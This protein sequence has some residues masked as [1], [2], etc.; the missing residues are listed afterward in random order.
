MPWRSSSIKFDELRGR[1]VEQGRAGDPAVLKG[2]LDAAAPYLSLS[3]LAC[4]REKLSWEESYELSTAAREGVDLQLVL[5]VATGHVVCL[6][7][8]APPSTGI[9]AGPA[10]ADDG[11]GPWAGDSADGGSPGTATNPAPVSAAEAMV[12]V[13]DRVEWA[14]LVDAEGVPEDGEPT[15][16]GSHGA[17]SAPDSSI[18]PEATIPADGHLDAPVVISGVPGGEPDVPGGRREDQVAGREITEEPPEQRLR[19][20]PDVPPP[21]LDDRPLSDDIASGSW[22]LTTRDALAAV[23]SSSSERHALAIN[24]V[25]WGLVS[26]GRLGL[27]YHLGRDLEEIRQPLQVPLALVEALVL[28][29]LVRSASS[30]GI[31]RLR[32]CLRELRPRMNASPPERPDRRLLGLALELCSLAACLRPALLAS[33]SG[34]PDLLKQLALDR[35]PDPFRK[36]RDVALGPSQRNLLL[37]ASLL[38]GDRAGERWAQSLQSLQR[39]CA[40]WL[41]SNRSGKVIYAA[42]TDVWRR[43]L[44]DD[45]PIGTM[46]GRVIRNQADPASLEATRKDMQDWSNHGHVDGKLHRTDNDLRQ[47]GAKRK[48]I[49]ARAVTAIRDRC[50]EAVALAG[51]WLNLLENRPDEQN[52]WITERANECRNELET[53]IGFGEGAVKAALES[54]GVTI[55][56][57]LSAGY[58]AVQRALDDLKELMNSKDDGPDRGAS[59]K[60]RLHG[61]LLKI[62]GLERS[63]GWEPLEPGSELLLTGTL[64]LVE[65]GDRRWDEV[66]A[67]CWDRDDFLTAQQIFELLEDTGT[68]A[69]GGIGPGSDPVAMRSEHDRRLGE[70]RANLCE[71][72]KELGEEIEK[73]RLKGLIDEEERLDLTDRLE[74]I[75]GE[76]TW[77]IARDR[78][79]LE[80]IDDRLRISKRERIEDFKKELLAHGLADRFPNG[81]GRIL[82]VLE[83]EDLVTAHEYRTIIERGGELPTPM[84]SVP[85]FDF[86]EPPE[87]GGEDRGFYYRLAPL[88]FGDGHPPLLRGIADRISERSPLGSI[89]VDVTPAQAKQAAQI[90]REWNQLKGVVKSRSDNMRESIQSIF[91]FI[92]FKIK[93]LKAGVEVL[94]GFRFQLETEPIVSRNDCILPD[95]GS[96]CD[97]K[98]ELLCLE[99][100]PL[101]D[102][103]L[104]IAG[105]EVQSHPVIVLF[106]APMKSRRRRELA[107]ALRLRGGRRLLVLDDVL[108]TYLCLQKDRLP[109]FFNAASQFS[110]AEPYLTTSSIPPEMFFGRDDEIASVFNQKGTSL[111][112]GGR[113]LGKTALLNEVRRR[114]HA[115]DRGVLVE[116]ID[117]RYGEHLGLSNPLD[118]I[119]RVIASRLQPHGVLSPSSRQTDTIGKE[120]RLWVENTGRRIVLLLDEADHFLASD[121]AEGWPRV[122]KLKT[123]MHDTH[124]QFKVVFS[125][126][127]NVQR[128]SHDV[129]TPLAHL[130]VPICIGPFLRDAE[131]RD[132]MDMVRLP[133]R[134]MGYYF[135]PPDLI[136]RILAQSNYY[137]SLIQLVCRQLLKRLPSSKSSPIDPERPPPSLSDSV[138]KDPLRTPPYPIKNSD[139]EEAYT[140]PELRKQIYDRFRW[141]LELDNSYR[142]IALCLALETL[143]NSERAVEG[144]TLREIREWALS[145]WPQ[146]FA[147]S[148]TNDAFR[149]LLDEMCELGVLRLR[150]GGR[151]SMRSPNVIHLLGTQE[152]IW[153]SLADAAKESR[154]IEYEAKSFRRVYDQHN[155]WRRSPLTA[156]QESQLQARSVHGLFVL[157]GTEAA[158]LDEVR[159]F[160]QILARSE[161]PSLSI[162]A[163]DD[164]VDGA[165]FQ[166]RLEDVIKQRER[167]CTMIL[168]DRRCRWSAEWV[169]RAGALL[170]RRHAEKHRFVKVLFLGG[171]HEAWLWSEL[172]EARRNRLA[173]FGLVEMALP[174]WNDLAVR[175]WKKEAEFGENTDEDSRRFSDATGNWCLFLHEVGGRC[176]E[177]AHEWNSILEE[178]RV[179][180]LADPAT[181]RRLGIIPETLPV[182]RH[183]RVSG[184]GDDRR[185]G[186]LDRLGELSGFSR[187]GRAGAAMGR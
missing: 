175:Q 144:F 28:S 104:R 21:A 95:F 30:E 160:L 64:D 124:G 20:E 106:F 80:N 66:I 2:L 35:F 123:L 161:P 6:D 121:A 49:N 84:Q 54:D 149:S 47:I 40:E 29:P 127:H 117:L 112:Y 73:A 118:D 165:W 83:S 184:T 61:D 148:Q 8:S 36:L 9:S 119:W 162:V 68:P 11:I 58:R 88:F 3:R 107:H 153:E 133:F 179:K 109:A 138:A 62:P 57:P 151:Y 39:R 78:S 18:P 50:G 42:T 23:R 108:L 31:W 55:P 122:G 60:F 128:T 43:W 157:M 41:S 155:K 90:L 10:T 152:H 44:R 67:S 139:V 85:G 186:R 4:E 96:R 93:N 15:V 52:N 91:K 131:M 17:S 7:E 74:A 100:V 174:S 129:N 82:S 98:Y 180:L 51:E 125:G 46:I 101:Q 182:L 137:P 34:A 103:I 130:G 76:R 92:G 63:E 71:R 126:L 116:L 154:K 48:P 32:E 113:Q 27:A 22:V 178:Y 168:V 156:D 69:G 167:D 26:D 72:R 135:E 1:L 142:V 14:P 110:I 102:E 145:T 185:A 166:R 132:A 87:V 173:G 16:G 53:A 140:D 24:G 5:A 141:T 79:E 143:E 89:T 25:I 187:G 33:A 134:A 111:V 97:G 150:E 13:A 170:A 136:G 171:P 70:A 147:E 146:G 177:R 19:P 37:S 181:P 99:G 169:E 59:A 81:H 159:S 164:P 77:Q 12:Q 38:A 45:G 163:I 115:P 114:Y 105:A 172:S 120:I 176:A 65:A 94:G 75:D 158:G 86:F 183:G 56:L